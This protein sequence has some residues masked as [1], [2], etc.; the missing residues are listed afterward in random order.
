[1]FM[2]LVVAE[3]P[4]CNTLMIPPCSTMN[5]RLLLSPAWPTKIGL[6]KPLTTV[7]S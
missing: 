5:R 2:K 4:D 7:V 1:M 3:A 6:V